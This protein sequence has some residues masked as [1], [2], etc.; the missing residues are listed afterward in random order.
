MLIGKFLTIKFCKCMSS[1]S[2]VFKMSKRPLMPVRDYEMAMP[3]PGSHTIS[4]LMFEAKTLRRKK[5]F[6]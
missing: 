1:Y 3:V 6:N 4:V 5:V 2:T